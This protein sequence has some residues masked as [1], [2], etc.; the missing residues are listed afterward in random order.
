MLPLRISSLISRP[1]PGLRVRLTSSDFAAGAAVFSG[2]AIASCC[3][4]A[5]TLAGGGAGTAAGAGADAET[6]TAGAEFLAAASS[7]S[8][9]WAKEIL[10]SPICVRPIA[11]PRPVGSTAYSEGMTTVTSKPMAT[12]KA[13]AVERTS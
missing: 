13:M 1:S 11:R 12:A 5:G 4:G 7:A 9:S 3:T 8:A 2:F 10:I 6:E